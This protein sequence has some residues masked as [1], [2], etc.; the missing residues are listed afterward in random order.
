MTLLNL[1]DI[2]GSGKSVE[3]Q[4]LKKT[5]GTAVLTSSKETPISEISVC[6]CSHTH[7]QGSEHEKRQEVTWICM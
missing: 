1:F 6:V 3:V 7:A 5:E 4:I 2:L